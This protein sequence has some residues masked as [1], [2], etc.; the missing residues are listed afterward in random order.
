MEIL[1]KTGSLAACIKS[2]G[3]LSEHAEKNSLPVLLEHEL[4][5]RVFT[6]HRLD[7]EVGGVMI[8]ALTA[9]AAAE[10][11]AQITSQKTKK[12]YLALVSGTV[13]PAEGEMRD[14][15]FKDKNRN[16]VYV[17]RRSRKGVREAVL[18]YRTLCADRERGV[19]LLDICPHTG[20]S[21]Q[22][23][24]Q[25]ASRGFPILGDRKYGSGT[26]LGMIALFSYSFAFLDPD[27]KEPVEVFSLPGDE[28]FAPY[29]EA[30]ESLAAERMRLSTDI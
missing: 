20:R 7:R 21:H 13:E 4:G 17:V 24:V 26:K 28:V 30:L 3:L 27:S 5:Q 12:R 25:L 22:I 9:Q 14:L 29:K 10:L 2:P 11:S 6:V 16:K 8:Y 15:L 19:T 18:E 1:Y 23:R